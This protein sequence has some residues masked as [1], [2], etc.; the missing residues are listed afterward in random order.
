MN[1]AMLA[2]ATELAIR[3]I[4]VDLITRAIGVPSVRD[5]L[6]G[7]RLRTLPAGGVGVLPRGRLSQ[8][9][10]EF[11]EALAVLAR[12]S[13]GAYDI[14]HSHYWLSGV[15][16]LPVC[17]ELGIPLVQSFH[18]LAAMKDTAGI[19]GVGPEPVVRGR[20]ET[21]IAHQA[22]AIVAASAAEAAFIID[23]VNGRAD[24][25]WIVPPGVDLGLFSPRDA[26]A[27]SR[28]RDALNIDL[29]RPLVALVGRIQPLKGH[30]LA[31]RSMAEL[32][33][34]QGWAPLL[35]IAGEPT[36]GDE[37]FE[38]ELREL[39]NSLGVVEDIQFVGAIYHD[40]LAEL[41][42][43]AHLTIMPSYTE[44]FGLVAIESAACG[45]PVIGYRTDGLRESIS[46]GISGELLG[47]REPREWATTI[48]ALIQDDERRHSL[49]VTARTFAERFSWRSAAASL[50][51]IYAGVG[52]P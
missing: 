29:V 45:T 5:L 46:E 15:A 22:D 44:T 23:N 27:A 20:S 37:G 9:T 21:F 51:G 4:Q 50:S 2:T 24:R 11:G 39:A 16:A 6:P 36:P 13:A 10:D 1:V 26:A 42:C 25:T 43:A 18:T 7:V 40:Q 41:L 38:R 14:I 33:A 17:L 3:G 19:P 31:I 32:R 8:H 47:T 35:V 52:R 48:A 12:S 30:E 28:V 34:S 49:G